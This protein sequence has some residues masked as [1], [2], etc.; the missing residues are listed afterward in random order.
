MAHQKE[1]REDGL[2]LPSFPLCPSLTRT[3]RQ[4]ELS[5]G[6][7]S[8]HQPV[9]K[10]QSGHWLDPTWPQ[11]QEN[12]WDQSTGGWSTRCTW[13]IPEILLE[14]QF[15][16]KWDLAEHSPARA[17]WHRRSC[18]MQ[19]GS[20]AKAFMFKSIFHV[21][22]G[23][24]THANGCI[25]SGPGCWLSWLFKE[26]TS[27]VTIPQPS[28]MPWNSCPPSPVHHCQGWV[29]MAGPNSCCDPQFN[30]SDRIITPNIAF[31]SLQQ[32]QCS[33]CKGKK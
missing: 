17:Q 2:L 33:E 11:G 30:C 12:G 29:L 4:G 6:R 22:K 18:T 21:A 7:L 26:L 27:R 5:L 13:R 3:G 23:K 10:G 1:H 8:V 20:P 15:L 24:N 19:W 14:Q 9:T 16:G 31:P 28:L 25:T 32:P